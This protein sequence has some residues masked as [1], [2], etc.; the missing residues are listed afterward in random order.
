MPVLR[1]YSRQGCHL[2]EEAQAALS[3]LG[4]T[5]ELQDI[6]DSPDL[7]HRYGWDVPVLVQLLPDGSEQLL[8]KGVINAARLR[9]VL[10]TVEK[11]LDGGQ[12]N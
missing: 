12:G 11:K 4:Y 2:C 7:E 3:R 9:T 6:A 8:A 5:F 1:L 10:R